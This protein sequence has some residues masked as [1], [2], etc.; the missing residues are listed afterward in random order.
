MGDFFTSIFDAIGGVAQSVGITNLY[1]LGGI[2]AA[3]GLVAFILEVVLRKTFVLR[4]RPALVGNGLRWEP[5]DLLIVAMCAAIFAV[6]LALTAGI[7]LVPG[8][9]QAR[10]ANAF[11][12]VFGI[13][14]GIPGVLGLAVGNIIG[15]ILSGTLTIGSVGGFLGIFMAGYIPYKLVGQRNPSGAAGIGIFYL[16]TFLAALFGTGLLISFWLQTSRILP[17]EAVWTAAFPS[18]FFVV[19]YPQWLFSIFILK[20]LYKPLERRG[21]VGQDEESRVV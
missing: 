3:I 5:R 19:L 2:M 17:P 20:A 18:I 10:P 11:I 12:A 16:A 8:F 13:L 1:I 4:P 7:Q 14:F 21:W 15:D 9:V 6:A